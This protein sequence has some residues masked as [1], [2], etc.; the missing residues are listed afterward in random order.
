MNIINVKA[1]RKLTTALA[2]AVIALAALILAI[3]SQPTRAQGGEIYVDK[4]LGRTDHTVYV[5]EYLTFTIFIRNDSTFT[6]TTLPMSDMYNNAVLGYADASVTP[7]SIDTATGSLDWDDLTDFFGDLAPGDQAT[8]IVGF[9]AE[10]PQPSVVNAAN[11]HDALL[12]N[13]Q[14]GEGASTNTDGEAIGGSSPVEKSLLA[15]LNPQVGQPLTFT[16]VITNDGFTTMT[17]APLTDMYLPEWMAFSYAVPPP[18]VVNPVDGIVSWTDLTD[19]FG[20][21]PPHGTLSVMTVFTAMMAVDNASNYVEV[22][23]ATDWFGN[24]LD[25]GGDDVPITIIGLPATPIPTPIP[26]PVP[27][28]RPAPTSVPAAPT[29]IPAPVPT[30]TPTPETVIFFLP[31]TGRTADA[32]NGPANAGLVAALLLLGTG[33]AALA[34]QVRRTLGRD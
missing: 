9:I 2:L 27:T 5:G 19:Y 31:Q 29:P 13:G 11:V 20:N 8:V 10:H 24:D 30:I 23:G 25:G 1:T 18:D 7:D 17:L 6:V 16:V 34:R 28:Q 33:A 3:S 22:S 32:K 14:L 4:Q 21:V 12:S 26:T 15:G